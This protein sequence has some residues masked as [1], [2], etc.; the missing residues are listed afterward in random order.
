[1]KK[2]ASGLFGICF[3][4]LGL[5]C[6]F[7]FLELL[8]TPVHVG[9]PEIDF[10]G[11]A[12]DKNVAEGYIIQYAMEFLVIGVFSLISGGFLLK[13]GFTKKNKNISL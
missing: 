8:T 9:I 4:I 10:Y 6:V 12:I 11:L 3:C 7:E 1:M 5:L 2:L 13:I